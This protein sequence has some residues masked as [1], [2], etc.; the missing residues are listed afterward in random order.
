LPVLFHHRRVERRFPID[1][2]WGAVLKLSGIKQKSAR[3]EI[4]NSLPLPAAD[5]DNKAMAATLRKIADQLD[6]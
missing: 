1:H 5:F 2:I 6:P 4:L 3:A